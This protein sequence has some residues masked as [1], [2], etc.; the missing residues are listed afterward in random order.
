M[1]AIWQLVDSIIIP[2]LTYA[3]DSCTPT[4]E[5]KAKLQ[6]VL[7]EANKKHPNNDPPERDWPYIPVEY[8]ITKKQI[9]LAKR[10][11]EMKSDSL[12]KDAT[13]TNKSTWR[14]MID[15]RAED[16]HIKDGM[17]TTK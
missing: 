1:K 9:L 14:K 6:T 13:I 12:I 4:K 16:L 11:D 5:D 15:E 2:I 8:I 3:C 17:A 7:N 10:I